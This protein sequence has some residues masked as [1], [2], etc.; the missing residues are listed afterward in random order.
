MAVIVFGTIS[1]LRRIWK[2][3]LQRIHIDDKPFID[4]V[5]AARGIYYGS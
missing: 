4:K 1:K 3:L 5:L 2:Q